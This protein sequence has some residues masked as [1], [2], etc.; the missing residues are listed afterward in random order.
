LG[1]GL[2]RQGRSNPELG[3]DILDPEGQG[4]SCLLR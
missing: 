1:F 4:R 3:S 2:S